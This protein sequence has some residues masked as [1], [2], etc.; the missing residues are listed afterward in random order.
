MHASATLNP[1]T[2][3][4]VVEQG[5]WSLH[6]LAVYRPEDQEKSL[7]SWGVNP[8]DAA[9][10]S[11]LLIRGPPLSANSTV[12]SVVEAGMWALSCLPV[13]ADSPS[14]SASPPVFTAATMSIITALTT[15]VTQPGVAE[16]ALWALH[17]YA[18]EPAA[19][20][21]LAT[22]ANAVVLAAL[23]MHALHRGVTEAGCCLMSRL[24]VLTGQSG[25]HGAA[26][27]PPLVAAL[28]AHG[29]AS[30]TI[31]SAACHALSNL[32]IVA[33]GAEAAIR[34]GALAAVSRVL[35]AHQ[36]ELSVAENAS[37]LL[38]RIYGAPGV[39]CA[40]DA[41][42]NRDACNAAIE[43]LSTHKS[44]AVVAEEAAGVITNIFANAGSGKTSL[45]RSAV[46][47][48]FSQLVDTLYMHTANVGVV[49][50]CLSSIWGLATTDEHRSIAS[51]SNVIPAI[52]RAL[53][54]HPA[55]TR[56]S[57]VGC[58]ALWAVCA[59]HSS[60]KAAAKREGAAKVLQAIKA[61]QGGTA[62]SELASKTLESLGDL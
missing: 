5:C 31:A 41:A 1:L 22:N 4:A 18:G 20:A 34:L 14:S 38:R 33:S 8:A 28:H 35:I 30:L 42:H 10:A 56:V 7:E 27:V 46:S 15:H 59:A 55:V 36:N 48:A 12:P 62:S 6:N 58:Q 43:C 61:R 26:A 45:E 50:A 57:E 47:S 49:T 3:G 25:L 40:T 9:E 24:S 16:G 52:V 21:S 60:N 53:N 2:C 51:S 39:A 54:A 13:V 37:R 44:V 17:K 32:T 23:S 11:A 29:E 19:Q